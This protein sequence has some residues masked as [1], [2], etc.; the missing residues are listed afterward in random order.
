MIKHVVCFKLKD[1]SLESCQN[2]KDVLMSMQGKVPQIRDIFIGIDFLHS[3]RSFDV[4]LEVLLDD[5]K[6][7]DDYQADPYHVDVV[8]AY[9]HKVRSDS[10]TVDY[11]FD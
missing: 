1:N 10:I 9:M 7:L 6:A 5:A 8:K 3:E 2:A 11:D 4:I